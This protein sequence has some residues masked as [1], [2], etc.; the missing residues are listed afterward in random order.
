M[1]EC[2]TSISPAS[3]KPLIEKILPRLETLVFDCW[4]NTPKFAVSESEVFEGDDDYDE[5]E[6]SIQYENPIDS[7]DECSQGHEAMDLAC[8]FIHGV[9]V[10][11]GII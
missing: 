5:F 10:G 9:L 11:K 1:W 3:A 2:K 6:L 4:H 7:H 8:A